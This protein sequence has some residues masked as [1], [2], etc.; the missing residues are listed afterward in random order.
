MCQ[1]GILLRPLQC[2]ARL[3]NL[4]A[5][6]AT[7]CFKI[8]PQAYDQHLNM[9][10]GEVEETVTTVEIDEETFEEIIK[11]NLIMPTWC[12]M[13]DAVSVSLA[14]TMYDAFVSLTFVYAELRCLVRIML[15]CFWGRLLHLSSLDMHSGCPGC[16]LLSG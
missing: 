7:L 13:V 9:I 15:G 2:A 4:S 14:S 11:V 12:S 8:C 5:Y 16:G 10:L 3:G 6:A 1:A